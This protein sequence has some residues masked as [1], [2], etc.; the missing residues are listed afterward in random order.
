MLNIKNCTGSAR[1]HRPTRYQWTSRP[2]GRTRPA[3][4]SRTT[5]QPGAVLHILRSTF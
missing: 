1:S 2:K 5:G 4:L 3:G